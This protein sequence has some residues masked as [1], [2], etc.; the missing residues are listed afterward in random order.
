MTRQQI[1][2]ATRQSKLALWQANFI[3]AELEAA[4]PGL[5]V[6]LLGMTTDG[7][8]W[9][10]SPLSEVGG[11][12]LFIKALEDAL[13]DGRADLAVHSMKDVPAELPDSFALPVIGYREDVRDALVS[14]SA[15]SLDDLPA[16][17]LIG[18]SSLRR[19]SMLL[20]QRGDLRVAPVRGN[21]DTRLAKLDSGEYDAIILAAAGLNRLGLSARITE[22]LPVERLLPAAG[23]GA[24][25]I[26]CRADDAEV[27]ALLQ[28]LNDAIANTCVSAERLVSAG[29][30]A[31][32]SAPLGCHAVLVDGEL[33]LEAWL[34]REDGSAQISAQAGGKS[35][36]LVS[37]EVV[38]SLLG[39][40][41]ADWLA[42][43]SGS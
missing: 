37:A 38:A 20:Q 32:C 30:G 2:I 28:P 8:R 29:L 12:G 9:L 11:K 43:R 25:G 13:Q 22:L 31:D 36:E 16:G 5:S 39:A 35:A 17:A 1:T 41:A 42:A 4:H 21:V 18:S 14:A 26:E 23:Q 15:K 7:D 24:L 40:G 3:K 10:S 6:E 33:Q 19:Q 34:L 27:V